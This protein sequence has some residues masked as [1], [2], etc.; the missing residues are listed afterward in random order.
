MRRTYFVEKSPPRAPQ[1]RKRT[2]CDRC[3]RDCDSCA[4]HADRHAPAA[5]RA[6][7]LQHL[8][9]RGS[10]LSGAGGQLSHWPG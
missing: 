8:R 3:F 1:R 6:S 9:A 5:G 10:G 4:G 2:F 7:G